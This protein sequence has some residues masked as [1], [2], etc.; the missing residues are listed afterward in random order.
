MAK[1]TKQKKSQEQMQKDFC[2]YKAQGY[3]N[4][5]SAIKAGYSKSYA[6]VSSHKL[7]D[8]CKIKKEIERLTKKTSEVADKKFSITAEQLLNELTELKSYGMKEE[9]FKDKVGN[10]KIRKIDTQCALSAIE[11]QAKIIGA[12]EVDNLQ[13]NQVVVERIKFVD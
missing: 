8:N 9:E 12:F 2:R 11:K 4:E 10:A 1:E 7:L 5:E 13:R 6:K 3:S